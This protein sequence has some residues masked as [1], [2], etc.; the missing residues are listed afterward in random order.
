LAAPKCVRRPTWARCARVAMSV[1]TSI[2]IGVAQSTYSQLS[3]LD[4]AH[5]V[6]ITIYIILYST[7]FSS[8]IINFDSDQ[9]P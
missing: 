6:S 7:M 9:V 5:T 2:P 3:L 4:Y 1:S 8:F